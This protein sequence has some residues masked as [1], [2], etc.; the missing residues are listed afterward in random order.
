[1]KQTL[2]VVSVI[3][4]TLC[5]G[6]QTGG[7]VKNAKLYEGN[8]QVR[9]V[10]E[11]QP[12]GAT[13]IT[14]TV[15]VNGHQDIKNEGTVHSPENAEEG[16]SLEATDNGVKVGTGKQYKPPVPPA[17]TVEQ[18]NARWMYVAASVLGFL[19]II[20]L[21]GSFTSWIPF[22]GRL[23]GVRGFA[24]A[25]GLMSGFLF[26][27]PTYLQEMGRATS[28]AIFCVLLTVMILWPIAALL[29]D[30]FYK[31]RGNTT[32][33]KLTAEAVV[34]EQRGQVEEAKDLR[35]SAIAARR[36]TDIT[37]DETFVKEKN[38]KKQDQTPPDPAPPAEPIQ[39]PANP[40]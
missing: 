26:I 36:T 10:V 11:P 15:T 19:C 4:L 12:N 34:A 8:A 18:L 20:G 17:P 3:L 13:K 9:T 38:K 37:Y 33:A 5:V 32:A 30:R 1:M 7:K 21:V 16:S 31:Q 24:V 22:I 40:D 6:C 25:C 35:N 29:R 39:P 2:A 23:A 27:L 28:I 14:S